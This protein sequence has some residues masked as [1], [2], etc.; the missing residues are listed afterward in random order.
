M[1]KLYYLIFIVLTVFLA[2][3]TDDF[4]D[5]NTDKKNPAEVAGNALF[6]NAQKDLSDQLNTPNVNFNN[7]NLW[8]QYWTETTYTDEANFDIVNRNVPQNEFRVSYRRVLRDLNEAATLIATEEVATALEGAKQNRLHIIEIL[9]VYVY[10]RLVDIFG[11]VPYTDAL[12][13]ENVYPSYDAGEDIY[14]DLFT[15]LDAAID[16]LDASS[17]S[18]GSADFYYNGSVSKWI[19][20]ANT[21]KIRM[22]I[23]IADY[24]DA[25]AKAAIEEAVAGAFTSTAD[26]C[27]MPYATSSPN[28]NPIYD[29]LVV[30]GRNDYVAA[31]TLID[32]MNGFNDPRIDNYFTSV[33]GVYIG[34]TYGENSA[35]PNFS[36]VADMIKAADF[37]GIILTYNELQFYLAEAAARGYTVGDTPEN[38]YADA[39]T[40]S[41]EWWGGTAG[42]AAT[43]LAQPEVDY[44]TAIAASAA[45]EPWREVIGTQSWIA[46]YVNGFV[47]WTTWRRLDYPVLNMPPIPYNGIT[48]VPTR[49]T[50]PINEQTLNEVNYAAAAAAVGGDELVTK[51][52]WD[53][54]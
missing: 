21:L 24:D 44:A 15:R 49:Y 29:N 8:A 20:F 23:T 16:G 53:I 43:Y 9:N 5:W 48:S 35:Y 7:F 14:D 2:S 12:N 51:I 39:I 42:D 17:G 33:G 1:K 50:F 36:H 22:A 41:I 30:S 28:Y 13:I 54:N 34:G 38:L 10:Q 19:K 37:P 6:S 47:G 45:T 25:T 52:F 11:M 27:L 46:S 26:D 31:N 18:F 32:V 3:C 40:T 4:E